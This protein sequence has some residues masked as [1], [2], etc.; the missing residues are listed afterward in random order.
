MAHVARKLLATALVMVP[1]ASLAQESV[2]KSQD[3]AKQLSNPV[4]SLISVPLQQNIDFGG[5]PDGGGVKSTL[6]IQPVVPVS[7]GPKWN[8]IVRTILPVVYQ[9]DISAPG[10]NEFGLGDTTQSFFFSPKQTG[11]GGIVW[12]VGPAILY[13]TATDRVLGSDKWG[14]GP[15]VV[16]L[17]Q[18][19]KDT[20]GLLANHIWSVAGSDTRNDISSTFF[21]PFYSHTTATATTYGVNLETSYDWKGENWVVPVNL[22]MSQLTKMGKQPIQIGVGA[23]YY[24]EKPTGG[25]DWGVRLVLTL[26][27]PK[28]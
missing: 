28:K 26:L 10:A 18:S 22:S 4:A 21:Q 24:I 6:N 25:P 11:S 8:V 15:T 27:F 13:P 7:L 23:R 12:G 9:S 5:G 20:Y 2:D 16:L 1:G 14:L 3:L 19:G 17:K